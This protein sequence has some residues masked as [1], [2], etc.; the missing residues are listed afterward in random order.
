MTTLIHSEGCQDFAQATDKTVVSTAA[1]N[2]EFYT[3]TVS[4]NANLQKIG[5]FALVPGATTTTC[6]T[7][8][9]LHLTGKKLYP[10]VNPMNVFPGGAA[11]LTA[12]K[13]LVAVYDPISF[14]NGFIDPTS[15][16][17]VTFDQNLPNFFNTGRDGSGVEWSGGGQGADLRLVDAN[18]V[19][20]TL[21]KPLTASSG[22]TPYFAN[23]TINIYTTAV[24]ANSKVFV[25]RVGSPN[26]TGD[27]V[28]ISLT[29]A[30]RFDIT[31]VANGGN[32]E[33][34]FFWLVVN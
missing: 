13:F 22:L 1:F 19:T 16:T 3:Y 7:G 6:P 29:M 31:A 20:G 8:R 34:R 18:A 25:T 33:G 21:A 23:T 11:P 26:N 4:T 24:T 12:K 17:F 10:D 32:G 30:S 14:L 15:S 28:Y 5:T 2:G 9:V 27:Y